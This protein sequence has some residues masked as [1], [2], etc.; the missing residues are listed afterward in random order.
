MSLMTK[1]TLILLI[2][3]YII[4]CF[5]LQPVSAIM[6][7]TVKNDV[8][9]GGFVGYAYGREELTSLKGFTDVSA[10]E[11][12]LLDLPIEI[13]KQNS[14]NRHTKRKRGKRGGIRQRVRARGT[15]PPLPTILLSNVRAIRNKM[16]ELE[17]CVRYLYEY[18]ESSLL[19]FT[20][21][22]LNS[23]VS[24]TTLSL[25]GFGTPI[26]LDR[27]V[28]STGK[29]VGGGVCMYVN[30]R[31]CKNVVRR[32]AILTQD[33][34]LLSVSFR[35]YYLPREFGQVFIVLVYI[36]PSA[37]YNQA[38]SIVYEQVQKLE[39]ISPDAPKFILGDFNGCTLKSVL[40]QYKQYVTCATRQNRTIDL[41]YGN[42]ANA[43]KSV[44]KPPLGQSD[45]NSVH[46]LPSYRQ[47]LKTGKVLTRTI[48]SW[49]EDSV[50]SLRGCFDCTDWNALIDSCCDI[51]EITEVINSYITFCTDS[52]IP[53]KQIKIFP[54]NKPWVTTHL[55][56][57]LNK[58]KIAFMRSDRE[59]LRS[60]E[61]AVRRE[62]QKCKLEYKD[63]VEKALQ[64]GNIRKAWTGI[65]TM[66]GCEK[67]RTSILTPDD[68]SFSEEL[69]TFYA[70]F[71]CHDHSSELDTVVQSMPAAESSI[72][73]TEE[74][75]CSTF[76]RINPRKAAGPDRICGT[77]LKTCAAQ[78]GYIF[79]ILFQMSLN[80]G[81]IPTLWKTSEIIPVPKRNKPSELNDYRPVALTSVIMK[82]LERIVLKRLLA[83]VRHLLDPFQFAY[84]AGRGVEDATLT[85]LNSVH[86]HLDA[87]KTY[88]RVLFVDFSSAFNTI[89][90]HLLLTKLKNMGVST[91]IS[92]WIK[93]FLTSRLQY[94]RINSSVSSVKV[95]NTGAPQGCVLSPV[96]FTLYTNDCVSSHPNNILVKFADDAALV[97]LIRDSEAQYRDEIQLFTQWCEDNFLVL[98]TKKTKELII[99]FR[100]NKSPKEPVVIENSAI[101]VVSEYKYLGTIIDDKLSWNQNT[102]RIYG[103]GQ[104]RLHF[105]R[106]LRSFGASISTM[107]LFYTMFIQSILSFSGPCWIGALSL[108]NRNKINKV[109]NVASK[110]A[111]VRFDD[112]VFI[113]E[114]QTVRLAG[115]ICADSSHPLFQEFRI[116]PSGR[117][118]EIPHFRTNRASRSFLPCSIK[119]LNMK[120]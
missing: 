41:C 91:T 21:T 82:C 88:V 103:R 35:P 54:N 85:M 40:P 59:E 77:V 94:V 87:G 61:K 45:H 26:R 118:L 78:L 19:C 70:R 6:S 92:L 117:R 104:Q 63:K 110:V 50:E 15:R 74:E 62:I 12:D 53:E 115:K 68:A 18:R 69:N 108:R 79:Q 48:R 16:D 42:I 66:I 11:L 2:L 14:Q 81:K 107:H 72:T 36:P 52:V 120:R 9:H 65:R 29:S 99:D 30:E 89:Q 20:E 113:C 56:D 17:A 83:D 22:W 7:P 97:G 25:S 64:L 43:Y 116:L 38:A 80:T 90:P 114:R 31:W 96:L 76:A 111:G 24:D 84:R 73:I 46:L 32:D 102:D 23:D 47:K 105:L 60:I 67:S 51:E 71:D 75:V 1:M 37:N 98:N 106:K 93:N 13:D 86:K 44:S 5:V 34:E 101:E 57:L 55:K 8:K 112:I 33:I 39:N 28:D 27:D 49:D 10:L 95:T 100:V 4:Q 3:T 58:K 109:V 119:L